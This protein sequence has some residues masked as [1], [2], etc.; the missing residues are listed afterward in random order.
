MS[1]PLRKASKQSIFQGTK[2]LWTQNESMLQPGIISQLQNK[3]SIIER[4]MQTREKPELGSILETGQFRNRQL[5]ADTEERIF[6]E[7]MKLLD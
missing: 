6:K 2:G 4:L 3:Q 5:L 7:V 1:S